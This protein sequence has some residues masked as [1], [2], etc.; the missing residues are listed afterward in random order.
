MKEYTY[1]NVIIRVHGVACRENLEIATIKFLKKVETNKAKRKDKN[2]NG[3]ND[4]SR[5]I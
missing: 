2:Q 1:N 5:N 3:N 4:T